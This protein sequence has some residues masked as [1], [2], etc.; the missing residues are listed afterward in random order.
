MVAIAQSRNCFSLSAS[1][2]TE[3]AVVRVANVFYNAIEESL[4]QL[5]S[6]Y[7]MQV[8]YSAL[9]PSQGVTVNASTAL[10]FSRALEAA[11]ADGVVLLVIDCSPWMEAMRALDYMPRALISLNCVDNSGALP[12]LERNFVSGAAQWDARL[13]GSDFKELDTDAWAHY[14]PINS[15]RVSS[16]ALFVQDWQRHYNSSAIPGYTY[17]FTLGGLQMLEAAIVLANTTDGILVNNQLRTLAQPSFY[18]MLQTNAF[19]F[20]Q[21]KPILIL[22][23]D[24]E[25]RSQIIGQ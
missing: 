2:A 3:L 23:Q 12:L 24:H 22:Q 19:G 1:S 16:P 18:G 6:D 17:A 25:G 14:A 15:S 10:L 4:H 13:E 21:F 8:I 20:N 7:R 11:A 5:A 9:V